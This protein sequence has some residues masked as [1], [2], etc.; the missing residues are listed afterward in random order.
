MA[1]GLEIPA[2]AL[3]EAD[4]ARI[5]EQAD[6]LGS[7]LIKG[8]EDVSHQLL[9]QTIALVQGMHGHVPDGGF[10]NT[11]T[12]AARKTPPDGAPVGRAARGQL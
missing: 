5:G 12:G 1:L 9:A 10:E 4:D 6:P 2:L 8:L 3:I 7:H 11:V